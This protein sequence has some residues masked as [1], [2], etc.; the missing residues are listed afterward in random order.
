MLLGTSCIT[1]TQKLK[2]K[3]IAVFPPPPYLL[4]IYIFTIVYLKVAKRG[5]L[6]V[7]TAHTEGNCVR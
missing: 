2:E 6:N 3:A 7:L 4:F 5:D 1:I